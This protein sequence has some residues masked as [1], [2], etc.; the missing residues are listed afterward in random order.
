LNVT[1]RSAQKLSIVF[2]AQLI[3]M[4]GKIDV[5]ALQDSGAEGS[6]I[7]PCTISRHRLPTQHLSSPLPVLNVNGTL[8][9]NGPITHRTQQTLRLTTTTGEH[10]NKRID[11]LATN[12]GKHNLILGTDWL[13]KHNRLINWQ[14]MQVNLNRCPKECGTPIFNINAQTPPHSTIKEIKDTGNHP[15]TVQHTLL[16]GKTGKTLRI[17]K[18]THLSSTH[19]TTLVLTTA[20][21]WPNGSTTVYASPASSPILT[22][23]LLNQA[24]PSYT[25]TTT[26]MTPQKIRPHQQDHHEDFTGNTSKDHMI[27]GTQQTHSHG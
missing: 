18:Y 9:A 6:L 19:L 26:P 8:N 14:T 10:H 1:G 17:T 11:L 3:G 5:S 2:N 20:Q 13:A 27:N 4:V 16:T 15:H 7:H 25:P 21:S 24:T 12:T 22:H 23:T